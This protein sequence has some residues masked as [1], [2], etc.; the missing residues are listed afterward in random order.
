MGDKSRK[1]LI[2][3]GCIIVL[4]GVI[5]LLYPFVGA[6]INS[7]QQHKVINEYKEDV[8]S[9]VDEEA[10]AYLEEARE[11]N[12][13]LFAQSESVKDLT[14]EQMEDYYGI[15]D[16]SVT[17]IMGYIEI[18]KI[19]AS[20][21][22]YHGVDE[23]VLQMGIG[24][25]PGSSFQV[26]GEDTHAVLTGHSGIPDSDLFT[27]LDELEV[28][29]TFSVTVLTNKATYKVFDISTELPDDVELKFEKGKDYCTLITCTPIGVNTHR[30]VV[31][32]ERVE[33]ELL[34]KEVLSF[35]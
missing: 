17:G 33:E 23:G 5:G 20:L 16:M 21:P 3:I 8:D 12:R 19:K 29:D 22:V 9:Y 25:L 28:G 13:W 27:R 4:G 14:D 35:D 10:E 18:P 15:L 30:L 6:W 32:G 1:I 26:G 7:L 2:T 31:R 11:Y 34:G 24:H